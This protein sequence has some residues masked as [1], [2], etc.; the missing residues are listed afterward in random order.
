MLFQ[1]PNGPEDGGL[2]VMNGTA[3]LFKQYFRENEAVS[4]KTSFDSQPFY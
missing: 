4:Q 3:P 1:L 2:A